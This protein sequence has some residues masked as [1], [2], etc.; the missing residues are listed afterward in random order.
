M[1]FKHFNLKCM[2]LSDFALTKFFDFF[3]IYTKIVKRP[4]KNFNHLNTLKYGFD[5]EVTPCIDLRKQVSQ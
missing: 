2:N 5:F 1:C 3:L 4:K